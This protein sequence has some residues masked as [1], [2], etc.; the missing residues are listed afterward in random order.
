MNL[1]PCKDP[2]NTVGMYDTVGDEFYD[3]SGSG[4]FTAGQ[5]VLITQQYSVRKDGA[6]YVIKKEV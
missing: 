2:D 4:T 5:E 6:R 3:N 1:I